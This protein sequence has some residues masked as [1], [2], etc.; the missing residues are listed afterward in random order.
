MAR[1]GPGKYLSNSQIFVYT[2][3][4]LVTGYL[5]AFQNSQ[6]NVRCIRPQPKIV[7]ELVSDRIQGDDLYHKT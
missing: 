4:T 5:Y 7:I 1:N 6:G 2:I 3:S